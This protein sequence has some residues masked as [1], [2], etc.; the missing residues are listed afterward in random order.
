MSKRGLDMPHLLR[1][2][3]ASHT[4]GYTGRTFLYGLVAYAVCSGCAEAFVPLPAVARI[5]PARPF[6]FIPLP[7]VSSA[8]LS[9]NAE[10]PADVMARVSAMMEGRF[11]SPASLEKSCVDAAGNAIP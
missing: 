3:H 6:S 4:L 7:L 1:D 10:D 5:N 2:L 8:Q 11:T 9:L